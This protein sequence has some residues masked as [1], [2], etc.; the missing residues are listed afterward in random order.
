MLEAIQDVAPD[1]GYRVHGLKIAREPRR[2]SGRTAI[3]APLSVH[4]PKHN[5]QQIQTQH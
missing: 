5:S 2:Y 3:R 4:E 1:A